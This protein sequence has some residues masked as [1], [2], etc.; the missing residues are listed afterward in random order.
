M[1]RP[2]TCRW[3]D[4]SG[5]GHQLRRNSG[6]SSSSSKSS[7]DSGRRLPLPEI[8]GSGGTVSGEP[9]AGTAG[10]A[11]AGVDGGTGGG[12]TD[13]DG[14]APTSRSPVADGATAGPDAVTGERC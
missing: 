13:A 11:P 7:L 5:E 3:A 2:G 9:E 8:G 1:G 10:R 14:V 4:S 12:V 6:M